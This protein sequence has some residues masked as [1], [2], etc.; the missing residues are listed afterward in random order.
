MSS[1][2]RLDKLRVYTEPYSFHIGF[3]PCVVYYFINNSSEIKSPNVSITINVNKDIYINPKN[4]FRRVSHIVRDCLIIQEEHRNAIIIK[5]NNEFIPTCLYVFGDVS[6]VNDK[7]VDDLMSNKY[8][9]ERYI[10]D[11]NHKYSYDGNK[12]IDLNL[13][14]SDVIG[15]MNEIFRRNEIGNELRRL[16]DIN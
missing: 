11:V 3:G 15:D 9:H 7:N 10:F 1:L 12:E 8:K 13:Y 16:Y 14:L 4:N 5:H 2:R 6:D